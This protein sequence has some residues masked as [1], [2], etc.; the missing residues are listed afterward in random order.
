VPID[1]HELLDPGHTAVLTMEL[2]RGVVGDAAVIPDLAAEVEARGMLDAVG[3]LLAAA[4]DAGAPVVH[5]TAEFRPDGRGSPANAPL[6][7][8]MMKAPG[9][10]AAGSGAVSVVPEL[11]PDPRDFVAPRSHGVSPFIGTS[12][13]SLLRTLHVRTVVATGVSVNLGLLGMCIEAVN[14]GY[15]V[16]VP[17][18]AVAGVPADYAEAV[19]RNTI[20]LVATRVTVDDVVGVWTKRA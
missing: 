7:A 12:L 18:D 4:R 15:R 8:K 14:F 3:R 1:L 11:G 5:C 19:M 6:L 10:M 13:D 16:A 9:H 20:A 2:Q 17:T